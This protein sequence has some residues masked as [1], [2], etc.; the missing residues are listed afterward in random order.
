MDLDSSGLRIDGRM[1]GP[2]VVNAQDSFLDFPDS[3]Y[4]QDRRMPKD[5]RVEP[6][7][8]FVARLDSPVLEIH[9][10]PELVFGLVKPLLRAIAQAGVRMV[11]LCEQ[12]K[13]VEIRLWDRSEAS[14]RFQD[15]IVQLQLLEDSLVV[16]SGI[17]P[18]PEDPALRDGASWHPEFLTGRRRG[19]TPNADGKWADA[20]VGT[21]R[22][23]YPRIRLVVLEPHPRIR[24]GEVQVLAEWLAK[25]GLPLAVLG[26]VSP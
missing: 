15:S 3:L 8:Q 18:I 22:R 20:L 10:A 13:C 21:T 24:M 2:L 9:C 16:G 4:P 17:A 12:G 11:K 25:S 26:N 23:R 1:L 5:D 6:L 14:E 19:D 7:R